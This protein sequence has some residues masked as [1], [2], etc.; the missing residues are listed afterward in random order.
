M[1]TQ[2]KQR[3]GIDMALIAAVALVV[4]TLS[5]LPMVRLVLELV[6]PQG[7][8]LTSPDPGRDGQFG[9]LD[10]NVAL[11]AGWYRGH[12]ARCCAGDGRGPARQPDRRPR[13][14]SLCPVLCCSTAHS[15]PGDGTG[16][17][18]DCSDRPV[19]FSSSSVWRRRSA[20]ETR[21]I[22]RPASSSCSGSNMDRWYF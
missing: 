5:I 11:F 8:F 4:A 7:S 12:V 2:I 9:N 18:A 14:E 22:R 17:V 15:T 6:M 19:P 3:Q 1:S 13:Q 10:G 21:F 20:A 16:L